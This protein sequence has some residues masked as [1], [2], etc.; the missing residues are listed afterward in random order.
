M[1]RDLGPYMANEAICHLVPNL[2]WNLTFSTLTQASFAG[3]RL[4][5]FGNLVLSTCKLC[6]LMPMLWRII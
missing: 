3:P 5:D 6:T 4:R 2:L 1:P